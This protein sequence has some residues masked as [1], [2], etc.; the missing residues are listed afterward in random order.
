MTPA[1]RPSGAGA[2]GERQRTAVGLL[3]RSWIDPWV[4][5]A[6]YRLDLNDPKTGRPAHNKVKTTLALLVALGA[7]VGLWI[8]VLLD[9]ED[10]NDPHYSLEL[11][12]AVAVTIFAV[13]ASYGLAGLKIWAE[14]RGGGAIDSLTQATKSDAE[15]LQAALAAAS[16]EGR[17][18]S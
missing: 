9:H 3:L 10:L 14:T 11:N 2:P 6:Y 4:D 7:A 16:A 1:P 15:V 13:F 12:V 5:Y 8:H 18:K 17:E